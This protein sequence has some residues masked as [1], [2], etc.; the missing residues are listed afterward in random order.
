MRLATALGWDYRTIGRLTLIQA[1]AMFEF[2]AE[3]PPVNELLAIVHGW[4]KPKTASEMLAQGAMGPEDFLE[5][6]KQ[7]GGRLLN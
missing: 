2:W 4:T 1:N 6:F 5:H 3:Q 7:T